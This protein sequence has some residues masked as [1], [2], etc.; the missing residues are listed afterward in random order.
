M[1][2]PRGKLSW[3]QY[4]FLQSLLR[5]YPALYLQSAFH[6]V[7]G[8]ATFV[9]STHWKYQQ[10]LKHTPS[11]ADASGTAGSLC[12]PSDGYCFNWD[13]NGYF[14]KGM[15]DWRW[16]WDSDSILFKSDTSLAG[17]S[18]QNSCIEMPFSI[19]NSNIKNKRICIQFWAAD[20]GGFGFVTQSEHY[21]WTIN[22]L[23]QTLRATKLLHFNY[24]WKKTGI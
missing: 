8:Y 6:H 18:R 13:Q 22:E 5:P 10:N 11:V 7:S 4:C 24:S 9:S 3:L 15:T 2:L 21:Q 20:K 1:M 17:V 12:C 19:A 14:Q 16:K 23:G